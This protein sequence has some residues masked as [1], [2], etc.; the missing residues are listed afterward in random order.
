MW[1]PYL[2]LG[3]TRESVLVSEYWIYQ[4][5]VLEIHCF[6]RILYDYGSKNTILYRIRSSTYFWTIQLIECDRHI[7]ACWNCFYLGACWN[8]LE[9]PDFSLNSTFCIVWISWFRCVNIQNICFCLRLLNLLFIFSDIIIFITN[10]LK[11]KIFTKINS[12]C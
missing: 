8:S 3:E 11:F 5:F 4:C 9:H 7:L 1:S 12:K 10:L 6:L 2:S